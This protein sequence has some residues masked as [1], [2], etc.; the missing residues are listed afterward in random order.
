MV[1]NR[2]SPV[3]VPRLGGLP[4]NLAPTIRRQLLRS[5]LLFVATS[6]VP[7]R[8]GGRLLRILLPL[9]INRFAG[10]DTHDMLVSVARLRA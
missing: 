7:K 10:R 2:L 8:D 1:K 3:A 6:Q 4:G 9:A 5:R